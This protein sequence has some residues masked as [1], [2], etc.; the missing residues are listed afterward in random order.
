MFLF[1]IR[2]GLIAEAEDG[3]MH[4]SLKPLPKSAKRSNIS[5]HAVLLD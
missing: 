1:A 5:D 3:E 4:L 2:T